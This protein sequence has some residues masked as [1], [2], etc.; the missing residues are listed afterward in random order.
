HYLDRERYAVFALAQDMLSWLALIDIGISGALSVSLAR[1]SG[2]PEPGRMVELVS[3]AFWTQQLVAI[4]AV[5]AGLIGALA[6]PTLMGIPASMR[7]ESVALV[8]VLV[9]AAGVFMATRSFSA[10]LI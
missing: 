4:V 9:A 2:R 6:F 8:V 3:T 5:A 10:V 7:S 1:L